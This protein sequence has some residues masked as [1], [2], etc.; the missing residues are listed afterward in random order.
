[1]H[2]KSARMLLFIKEFSKIHANLKRHKS[3]F[4][5]PSKHTYQPMRTRVV[6]EL[7]YKNRACTIDPYRFT[8]RKVIAIRSSLHKLLLRDSFFQFLLIY[9]CALEYKG[10]SVKVNRKN[11]MVRK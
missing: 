5:L 7:F 8:T 9:Q 3:V 10:K 2:G 1:M 11:K 6:A 4:I